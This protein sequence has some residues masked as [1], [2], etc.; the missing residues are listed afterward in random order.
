MNARRNEPEEDK[1]PGRRVHTSVGAV[2]G[3][4]TAAARTPVRPPAIPIAEMVGGAIGGYWGGRLPD[5]IEP[6]TSPWHR[7]PAHSVS[8]ATI[9]AKSFDGLD[10]WE[11][12]CRGRAAHHAEQRGLQGADSKEALS[13]MLAEWFWRFLAGL[14]AGLLSGYISHMALDAITSRSLP[15]L[16]R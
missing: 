14:V 5:L 13:H 15:L 8:L 3:G 10:R 12:Y 6:A 1:L 9:L 11:G 4:L 16:T 7:G 2:V